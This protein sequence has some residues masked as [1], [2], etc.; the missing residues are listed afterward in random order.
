MRL[1]YGTLV[2]AR[3]IP[4]PGQTAAC[5]TTSFDIWVVDTTGQEPRRPFIHGS[6][7]PFYRRFP[8]GRR[9]TE[10][11]PRRALP[12]GPKANLA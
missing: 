8:A 7:R 11:A 6:Q 12:R 2:R 10:A 3:Q 1:Q 9:M 5:R 4:F